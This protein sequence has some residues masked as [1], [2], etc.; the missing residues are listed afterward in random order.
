MYKHFKNLKLF[1][2]LGLETIFFNNWK[3]DPPD[4]IEVIYSPNNS[5]FR[6]SATFPRVKSADSAEHFFEFAKNLGVVLSQFNCKPKVFR[7]LLEA[8]VK[9]TLTVDESGE[10]SAK[11]VGDVPAIFKEHD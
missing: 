7:T 3:Y 11:I 5:T 8:S 2:L 9:V 10:P 4:A 1:S 6:W